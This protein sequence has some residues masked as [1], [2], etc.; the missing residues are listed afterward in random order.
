MN[1]YGLGPDSDEKIAQIQ[2]E[3]EVRRLDC[4]MLSST[5]HK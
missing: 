2:K 5:D 3:S 4:I 1:P